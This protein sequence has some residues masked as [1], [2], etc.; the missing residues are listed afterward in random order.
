MEIK[1]ALENNKEIQTVVSWAV[2]KEQYATSRAELSTLYFDEADKAE[3]G[4]LKQL[5]NKTFETIV[6]T[7]M[8]LPEIKALLD[9]ADKKDPKV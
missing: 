7:L 4:E 5:D 2:R 3:S 8:E 9:Q 6:N 1:D